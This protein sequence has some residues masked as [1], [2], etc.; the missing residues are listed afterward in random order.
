MHAKRTLLKKVTSR[1]RETPTFQGWSAK[2]EP[3]RQKKRHFF[4]G[5]RY[6]FL[7][8]ENEGHQIGPRSKPQVCKV[9]NYL[10]GTLVDT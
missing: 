9:L 4:Q 3:G 2:H 6:V 1:L 8:L 7:A 10:R 5:N